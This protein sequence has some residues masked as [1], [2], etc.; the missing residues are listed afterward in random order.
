MKKEVKIGIIG[1]AAL[2]MLFFGINYLKGVRM[3]HASSYYYVEYTD[4]NGLATSSPVFASGYKVGLVREIQYNHANPGHVVVEVELD[5]GMQIPKG[6]T[7]ELVTE[8]L[9]TVKM[10]LKLN[11]QSKEYCQPGDTLP[12]IV[13]N[14]LMGVAE[15]I[16]PKVEQLMPKMDSILNSL[17]QLLANPA[18]RGTLENTERLTANLDVTTRQLNKLM[19][20]DLPQITSRM[21]TIADNFSTI[22]ESLKGIDYAET[23]QK[24]DST[25]QNVQLLTSKLNS[26]DNTVGLL[27][28]DPTLYNNLS[29]TTA[30]AASLL[31]DL[32][33]HPKRYVHFSL[34]G[35]KDKDTK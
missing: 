16:M 14:G 13:N 32:Q 2:A 34:F 30:N 24:I 28:N 7:G 15:G 6:S 3:F 20:N 22:S 31:E 27:F 21:I 23:F 18:L 17:N 35:R 26:K 1:I 4:I 25:L 5:K 29:A 9:G 8:M 12:G 10:N 19:Q 33:A 11:L